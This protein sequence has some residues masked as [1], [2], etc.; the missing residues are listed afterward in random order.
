MTAI[1]DIELDRYLVPAR[2]RRLPTYRFDV[3]VVG[4][5]GAGGFAALAAVQRGLSVA[6]IAKGT[7]QESNTLYAQ[8]GVAAV[9]H[10]ED[11]FASHIQDTLRVGCGLCEP[12][13]V[14]RVVRGGPEAIQAIVDLGG[15]F[16][17]DARGELDLSREGGHSHPRIVHAHGAATGLEIQRPVARAVAAHEDIVCFEHT[18][19]IDL[20]TRPVDASGDGPGRVVGVLCR[21][22]RGEL[23][24]FQASQVVLATGGSGQLYRETTNP[25][26]ATGDGVALAFRAGATV[27]DLEFVQFHPTCLYIAGA[28]R[29]L[30][31]E[32]V[33]GAGGVLRDRSGE[34]FM[35]D[36]HASAELAPRDVVSRAAFDRMVQ[37]GDTSVYLDLS[38]LDRDPHE[39]FPGI[40]RICGYFGI[41]IARDPIPVRPGAHYQVGGVEVDLDGRTNVPGLWAVGECASTGLHGANRMGSNSLLESMV[42]GRLVGENAAEEVGDVPQPLDGPRGAGR[43]TPPDARLSIVDMTYS[44]KS[45]MWRQMGITRESALMED[46]LDKIAFW[47]RAVRDLGPAE[48]STWELMNMLTV[49]RLA[50][51]SALQREE[52]RGVHFRSDFPEASEAW[53]VHSALTAVREG[54]RIVSV[55]ATRPAVSGAVP[56]A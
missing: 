49:A 51:W 12:A 17:L 36:Y 43:E 6:V 38:E 19:A 42:L 53:R 32:I 45:L 47:T 46:A 40:S 11:S 31:S 9:L 28:A 22:Q 1:P 24:V 48:P 35:P 5:G 16:D 18:R 34:R 29:V 41:D 26:I 14:E 25:E 21:T 3:V 56:T 50:A 54:D 37:T 7:L 39:L 27:R 23:V 55:R 15:Q 20:L 33:R 4:A 30:I 44:L 2:A 8:G 52:S 13:A 10:P